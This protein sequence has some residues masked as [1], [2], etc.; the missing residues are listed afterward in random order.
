MQTDFNGSQEAIRFAQAG[1]VMKAYRD[2]Y[3]REDG[4]RGISQSEVLRRMASSDP[5]FAQ[6]ISH[7]TVSRWESGTT[8]PTVER[9]KVFGKAMGLSETEVEGLIM[10]AGLD[11]EQSGSNS[12]PCP[13]CG[14][15]TRTEED[16]KIR[17]DED[18]TTEE[19]AV[20]RTRKCRLCGYTSESRERWAHDHEE[21][22]QNR[23]KQILRE[24][25]ELNNRIGLTLLDAPAVHLQQKTRERKPRKIKTWLT[26]W[27]QTEASNTSEQVP[28]QHLRGKAMADGEVR[29]GLPES[30][31]QWP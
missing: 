13:E 3:P 18:E 7:A 5:D 12:L 20:I 1:F 22:E 17:R 26:V 28:G 15:E 11:P 19:N 30:L 25:R 24:I 23:T 10:L 4:G 14:G 8:P 16:Q 6:R 9:L 27:K 21:Q 31:R 29:G 2:A